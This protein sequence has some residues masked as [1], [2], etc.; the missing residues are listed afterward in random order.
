VVD[1]SNDAEVANTRLIHWNLR[2][3]QLSVP[4]SCSGAIIHS[5]P[6]TS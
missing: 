2:R 1:V 6:T 4:L 5:I 3:G